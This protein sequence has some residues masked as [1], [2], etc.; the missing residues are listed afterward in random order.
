M[1]PNNELRA[2]EKTSAPLDRAQEA[3]FADLLTSSQILRSRKAV[4]HQVLS[5]FLFSLLGL[6]S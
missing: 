5:H 1:V 2:V 3:H 4:L 6:E